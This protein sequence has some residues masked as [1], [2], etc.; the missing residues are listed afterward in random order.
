MADTKSIEREPGLEERL[1]RVGEKLRATLVPVIR[2]I[3]GP[4]PRPSRLAQRIEIDKSLA[5]RLS[6][7]YRTEDPLEF[8]HVVPAPTGLRIFMSAAKLAKVNKHLCE[9]AEA[10]IGAFQGLIDQT[11]GGRA[12]LDASISASSPEARSRNERSS[13]QAV[14][15]AMSY[16]LGYQC[17]TTATA[18]IIQ[19]AADG[20][21]VDS[22]DI[23]HRLR[24]RRLRPTAPVGLFS[25]RLHAR[26]GGAVSDLRFE[27]LDA[28]LVD[29]VKEFFLPDFSSDPMPHLDVFKNGN[30]TTIALSE[31][32]PPPEAP[33]D[34][35]FAALLRNVLYQYREEDCA[36]GWRN[37]LLHTPCK[38][39][40]RDVFIR[41]DLYPGLAPEV[42][43]YI[44][45]PRGPETLRHPGQYGRMNTVDLAT[46]IEYL[47]MGL[48]SIKVREMPG[49]QNLIQHA[50]DRTGWDPSR[51]RVYRAKIIYPVPMIY[52]NWWFP[53]PERPATP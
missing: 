33:F 52:M 35:T 22:I 32:G 30:Q 14:Y 47:G 44:P 31:D 40:V 45:S 41:D 48:R 29:D 38:L 9:K 2:E 8:M 15:K 34:L 12:T 28:K 46:P 51:F 21:M 24:I 6:R 39:L 25:H 23:N 17:D 27:T 18:F 50:F 42:T 3:A 1:Q 37:Y 11:P 16:L 19:P 10:S 36:E 4:S 20:R 53:L 43:L 13:K 49:Y 5:S 7:A 26:S